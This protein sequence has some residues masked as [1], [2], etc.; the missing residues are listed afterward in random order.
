MGLELTDAGFDFS[1]LCEF[2]SRLL[3]GEAEERLLELVL[4]HCRQQGLLKARGQQRTDATHVLA[5]V[6]EL[7]RLELVGETLRAALNEIATVEP[8]W[9]CQVVPTDWYQRHGRRIEDSRPPKTETARQ[10]YAQQVGEDGFFLLDLLDRPDTLRELKQLPQIQA[11][12]IAWRRHYERNDSPPSDGSSGV[13]YKTHREVTQSPEKIESPYAIEARFRTKRDTTWT[14]Y[15]AHVSETCDDNSVH[16]ITHV[17]TTPA[18]VHEA[19]CTETIQHALVEKNLPPKEHLVD[20]AYIDAELL[21]SSHDA[22]GIDLIGPPR[23]NVSWQATT[24]GAYDLD[25]FEIDWE[26]QQ[27]RCPQGKWSSSWKEE[28]LPGGQR[29]IG[30]R[31]RPRDCQACSARDLCTRAKQH[32][33]YLHFPPQA[34]YEAQ[35]AARARLDSDEGRKLYA[36]RSGIEGTLSH[37]VRSFGLRQTRYQGQAKTHLQQVAAAAAVNF[38]RI[39]AWLNSRP[40]A[41]T[42]TSAFA[43]L[44]PLAA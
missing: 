6:R 18:D 37:S 14:G 41:K 30:V 35:Q 26:R 43:A 25:H 24:E 7:N 17:H 44:E 19:K 20:A 13:R 32:G 38:D 21:V 27:A 16:L 5:A 4:D 33:R 12:R 39:A 23:P 15:M 22:Q 42:R 11:L 2:R 36:R 40:Q 29:S 8:N 34:R 31:F 9:L 3:V 1:V 10:A 28:V